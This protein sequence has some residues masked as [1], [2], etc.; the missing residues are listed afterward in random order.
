MFTRSI[1]SSR[2]LSAVTWTAALARS[3]WV[4]MGGSRHSGRASIVTGVQR[5]PQAEGPRWAPCAESLPVIERKRWISL[6][7][8]LRY[9]H[10]SREHRYD[11]EQRP[12][13]E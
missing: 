9:A 8:Q 5:T 6:A 12:A 4:M 1:N 10:G 2:T 13:F 7:C 3:G 11:P